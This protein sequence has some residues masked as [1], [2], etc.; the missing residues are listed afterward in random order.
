MPAL[1]AV[2]VVALLGFAGSVGS[3]PAFVSL[4][5]GTA[6]ERPLAVSVQVA[7]TIFSIGLMLFTAK[8]MLAERRT[9][10]QQTKQQTPPTRQSDR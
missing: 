4:V 1:Y 9:Q 10:R 8:S 3:V 5:S 2:L 7:M 6:V